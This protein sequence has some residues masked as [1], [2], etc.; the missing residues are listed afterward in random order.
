MEGHTRRGTVLAGGLLLA[1]AVA[2]LDTKLAEAQEFPTF[3]GGEL[4]AGLVLPG[5]ADTAWGFGF[6]VDLGE[7]VDRFRVYAGYHGFGADVSRVVRDEPL[8][9]DIRNHGARLGTRYA[10]RTNDRFSPYLTAS[11]TGYWTSST[12]VDAADQGLMDDLYQGARLGTMV[13]LGVTFPLEATEQVMV[14]S[15]LRRAFTG[16]IRHWSLDLGLRLELADDGT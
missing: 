15:E 6:D 12:A 10:I 3:A 1:V 9:G 5:D 7:V 2:S 14:M 13:G 16:T 8:T 4:R 11:A